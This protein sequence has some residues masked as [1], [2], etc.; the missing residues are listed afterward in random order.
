MGVLRL[1][2]REGF[3]PIQL[4]VHEGDPAGRGASP[5]LNYFNPIVYAKNW[6]VNATDISPNNPIVDFSTTDRVID[7]QLTLH[8]PPRIVESYSNLDNWNQHIDF[9][10]VVATDCQHQLGGNITSVQKRYCLILHQ[11]PDL[12]GNNCPSRLPIK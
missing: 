4:R 7:P 9:D 5:P 2:C 8:K 3:W 6:P 11:R 10:A 1:T 12:T